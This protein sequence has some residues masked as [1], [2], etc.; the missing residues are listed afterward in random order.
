MP[1]L[2]LSHVLSVRWPSRILIREGDN[3]G[4]TA[5]HDVLAAAAGSMPTARLQSS[6]P[7]V[8]F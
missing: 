6:Y 4:V 7:R 5:R 3:I 1:W 8:G 2:P